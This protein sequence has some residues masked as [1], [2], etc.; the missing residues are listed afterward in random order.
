[1]T[2]ALVVSRMRFLQAQKLQIQPWWEL[3]RELF[4]NE[5]RLNDLKMHI[6]APQL[7][8][9]VAYRDWCL[10]LNFDTFFP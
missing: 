5:I 10:K 2:R 9:D 1:M 3:L 7:I 4:D 8:F 6:D